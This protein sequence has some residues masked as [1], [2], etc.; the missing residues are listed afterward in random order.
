MVIFT[1]EIIRFD[2]MKREDVAVIAVP[3]EASRIAL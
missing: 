2:K 1:K 3:F